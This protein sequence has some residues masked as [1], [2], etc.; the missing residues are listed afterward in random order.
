MQW[1]Q[2]YTQICSKWQNGNRL[3]LFI[4]VSIPRCYDGFKRC[5]SGH[6]SLA[7]HQFVFSSLVIKRL[8]PQRLPTAHSR[9]HSKPLCTR[10]LVGAVTGISTNCSTLSTWLPGTVTT[11]V[12]SFWTYLRITLLSLHAI[13]FLLL[14]IWDQ[15]SHYLDLFMSLVPQTMSLVKNCVKF[16]YVD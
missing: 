7:S 5:D 2:G 10:T 12:L 14:L 13:M 16:S 6:V 11:S 15:L 8:S 1:K 4:Y 9:T 3:K